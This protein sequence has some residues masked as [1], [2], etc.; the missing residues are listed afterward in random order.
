MEAWG[1]TRQAKEAM[2]KEAEYTAKDLAHG[3]LGYLR[4]LKRDRKVAD[5]PWGH[6]QT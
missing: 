2:G 3:T 4:R 1:A 6:S 5:N